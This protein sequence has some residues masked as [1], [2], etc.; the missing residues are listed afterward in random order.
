MSNQVPLAQQYK[1][2]RTLSDTEP[3]FPVTID[4][5]LLGGSG[6]GSG[7][8]AAAQQSPQSMQFQQ[9]NQGNDS[10]KKLLT[11]ISDSHSALVEYISTLNRLHSKMRK[12]PGIMYPP[13]GTVLDSDGIQNQLKYSKKCRKLYSSAIQKTQDENKLLNAIDNQLALLLGD[14]SEDDE[15]AQD[16]GSIKKPEI[17]NSAIN[18]RIKKRRLDQ[19]SKNDTKVN[20]IGQWEPNQMVA[21]NTHKSNADDIW[22][23]ARIIKQLSPTQNADLYT[24]SGDQQE[25]RFEVEDAEPDPT[26]AEYRKRYRVSEKNI[27]ILD[28][29][30]KK[31][32]PQAVVLALFPDTSCLYRATYLEG[33]KLDINTSSGYSYVVQFEEDDGRRRVVDAKYIVPYPNNNL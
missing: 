20:A 7:G 1:L 16:H 23:L 24:N 12:N 27:V 29:N 10:L 6:S 30:T 14:I 33:P 11:Q 31:F 13:A 17:P 15:D 19:D 22:I 4:P 3:L 32:N 5:S 21:I 26:S 2:K 25:V 18:E 9:D 8:N 28:E